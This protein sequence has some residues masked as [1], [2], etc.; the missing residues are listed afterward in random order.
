MIHLLPHKYSPRSYQLSIMAAVPNQYKRGVYVWHRR[1]GKD[2]SAW[3]K[4]VSE[5]VRHKAI[6]YYFF[7]TYSQGKKVIWDSI[8]EKTGIK[9]IDHIPSELILR[10]NE[11]DMKIELTNGSLIQVVG[12]D[13][14]NSIMGS[15]PY[16]CVFSEFALQDPRAWDFIRPILR[17]NGGWAI[18]LFTP[19]GKNHAWE[20]YRMAQVETSWF[21]ELLTVKE[22]QRDDGSPVI[23]DA[24]IEQERREGV[25]DE[26][27]DQEYFCSFEGMIM[28]A[29][30]S[31]MISKLRKEG[32]MTELP[33][34]PQLQ[35]DTFW[36]LGID[37]S[38]AI[39]FMQ[40]VGMQCRFIDYYEASGYGLEHYAKVLKEKEY[41]YGN[42]HMPH[43]ADVRELSSGEVAQSRREVAENL[44]IKPVIVV[45]RARDI[46]TIMQI[47][48]PAVRNILARCWFD[49]KKCFRGISALEGYRAD[50]D[51]E[52]KTVANRPLHDWCSHGADAFRTFAM[53]WTETIT[54]TKSDW[55][56]KVHRGTWRSV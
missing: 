40:A 14:F 15:N 16:G 24:D 54:R 18:F 3:N 11:T 25:A 17:E 1:A 29:Y 9:F 44:G 8:D 34:S 53:G 48:I 42:H 50:Y 30:Y 13:N 20:M 6:Y 27:I 21:A 35:V 33:Y 52:K 28:G 41:V 2:R 32:H 26:M 7:P 45:P 4:T 5:A 47:H 37:D 36:D 55:R 38:M 46:N 22:T 23:T 10:K 12:S 31:K 49:E 39:W 43:D 51:E 19:R 56:D